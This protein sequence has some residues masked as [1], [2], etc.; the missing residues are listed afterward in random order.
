LSLQPWPVGLPARTGHALTASHCTGL[1]PRAAYSLRC[2]VP[3][4]GGYVHR[5]LS[6]ENINNYRNAV[7]R[8]VGDGDHNAAVVKRIE[9]EVDV[10][11]RDTKQ[12]DGDGGVTIHVATYPTCRSSP[13]AGRSL[14]GQFSVASHSPIARHSQGTGRH[15]I[16]SPSLVTRHDL[17]NCHVHCSGH[18]NATAIGCSG[19]YAVVWLP[20]RGFSAPGFR[21]TIQRGV[22]KTIVCDPVDRGLWNVRVGQALYGGVSLI[23]IIEDCHNRADLDCSCITH[24]SNSWFE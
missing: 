10:F 11:I 18:S 22:A 5:A 2:S 8:K 13:A 16:A 9:I 3:F 15:L 1:A 23:V 4:P 24:V 14:A 19:T 17:T 21:S 7:G 6:I 12:A 20:D